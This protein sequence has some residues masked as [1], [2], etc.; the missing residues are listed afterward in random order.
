MAITYLN[1]NLLDPERV[2]VYD[3]WVD[4]GENKRVRYRN[5]GLLNS[6]GTKY[7]KYCGFNKFTIETYPTLSECEGWINSI[8]VE[9]ADYGYNKK[10]VKRS[11][12]DPTAKFLFLHMCI[13]LIKVILSCSKHWIIMI[14]D[15]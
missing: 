2:I 15:F 7:H 12:C 3:K 8:N 11:I 9:D 10:R 6:D 14:L 5:I 4:I 13:H 1:L